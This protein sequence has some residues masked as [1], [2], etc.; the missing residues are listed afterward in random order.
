MGSNPSRREYHCRPLHTLHLRPSLHFPQPTER[1][2]CSTACLKDPTSQRTI[3]LIGLVR[4]PVPA[5][6]VFHA[7]ARHG[8]PWHPPSLPPPPL[9]STLPHQG[10][11]PMRRGAARS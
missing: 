7:L 1:P 11:V 4:D 10:P 3:C 8:S 2:S 9:L 6:H 5:R